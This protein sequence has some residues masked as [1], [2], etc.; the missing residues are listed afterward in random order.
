MQYK[1]KTSEEINRNGKVWK[2]A[3]LTDPLNDAVSLEVSVWPDYA[4]Y[5]QVVEGAVVE[6]VVVENKGY[7]NL[8]DGNLGAKPAQFKQNQI[9]QAMEQKAE[10]IGAFQES[11]EKGIKVAG[12]FRAAAEMAI[13]EY[14]R[15][16]G[17]IGEHFSKWRKQLWDLWEYD[18]EIPF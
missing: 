14:N 13:A 10:Q 2:K 17:N 15:E 12:T 16:G 8:K 7:K 18:N 3:T 4:L 1:I 9:K 11:K 6:G 5:S